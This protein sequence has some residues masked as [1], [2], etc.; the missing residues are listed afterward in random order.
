M[1]MSH[2]DRVRSLPPGFELIGESPNSP[3]AA[4]ADPA[5]RITCVQFHPEVAHT[6]RGAEI[7]ANFLFAVC[8]ASGYWSMASFVDEAVADVQ[9]TLGADGR[10]I[11]GL[12]GGVDSSVVAALLLARGGGRASPASSSTTASCAPASARTWRRCSATTS[13]PTCG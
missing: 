10:V 8:G 1:W 11:C 7:L 12:S 9:T 2:G 3:A 6:P 5:R 4:F 13:A